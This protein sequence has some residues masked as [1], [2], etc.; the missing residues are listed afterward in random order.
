MRG[1]IV[2]RKDLRIEGNMAVLIGK[3]L[4]QIEP[5]LMEGLI[6]TLVMLGARN[7]RPS[8]REI[9]INHYQ[10]TWDQLADPLDLA[11][12]REA[13]RKET[14][15][16]RRYQV[17][18][19]LH[20]CERPNPKWESLQMLLELE[21]NDNLQTLVSILDLAKTKCQYLLELVHT[22]KEFL[23]LDQAAYQTW[24]AL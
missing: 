17:T 20:I 4:A 5:V 23:Q 12:G 21:S 15:L 14:L 11:K 2:T 24:E 3:V 6:E 8:L 16:E 1:S 18:I 13:I 10:V 19:N 22:V 9:Q 7:E